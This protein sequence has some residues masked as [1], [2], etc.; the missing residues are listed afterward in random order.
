MD[1]LTILNNILKNTDVLT[2][3]I[4]FLFLWI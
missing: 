4:C 2:L 3:I 1:K